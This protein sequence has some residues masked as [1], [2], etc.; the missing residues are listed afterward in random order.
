MLCIGLLGA[1][2]SAQERPSSPPDAVTAGR[3]MPL[4]T[5]TSPMPPP[6]QTTTAPG[7]EDME[8]MEEEV[9]D[10]DI[11][12]LRSR[13]VFRYDYKVQDGPTETNRFRLKTFYAFG[14]HKRL[15]FSVNVPLVWKDTPSGFAFGSGDTEITAGGNLYRTETFRT[16]IT[17][18][19]TL[20]TSS[21]ELIGGSSTKLKGSW[22]FS[23]LFNNRFELSSAFHYKQSVHLSRGDPTKQFEPDITLSMRILK[24][25]WFVESDSYYDLIPARFAPMLK[26]GLGRTLG[27]RKTWTLSP[28]AEWPL[29]RYARQTQQRLN[30]GFDVT[31]YPSMKP[32]E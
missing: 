14:P 29:N 8:L 28:Y 32:S 11:T 2:M 5:G 17:G 21:D 30:V 26:T 15:A 31:W 7:T 3:S 27:E 6:G 9:G 25:T 10:R 22:G 13:V 20:Q 18:Q 1:G 16:G 24:A 19:V 12:Y 4:P 23:Y